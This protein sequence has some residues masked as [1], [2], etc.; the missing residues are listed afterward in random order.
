M[1]YNES[2]VVR[3]VRPKGKK[4]SIIK[5]D[6]EKWNISMIHRKNKDNVEII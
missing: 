4:M 2:F 3:L 6:N 1:G 5:I